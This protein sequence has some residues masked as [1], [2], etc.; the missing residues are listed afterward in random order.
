MRGRFAA[1]GAATAAVSM[2]ALATAAVAGASG[3]PPLPKGA[4][5]AK[6]QL[7]A[8]GL[9]TPTS[10]AFG[11][12]SVFAGDGGAESSKTPNGGIYVL[13]QGA[14]TKIAG[15][16]SFVAGLAWHQGALYVSGGGITKQGPQFSIWKMSGWNGTSFAKRQVIFSPGGKFDGFNGLAFGADGRLYVGVDL[17]LTN[18][19]DHGPASAT[20]HLYQILS[21]KP[22]GK[23]VTTFAKGIRQPWQFVFPAGSSS[24]FVSALGQ[25]K[26]AKTAPDFILRVRQ[27][28]DY[29]FPACNQTEPKACKGFTKPFQQFAPH[30]DL[31][32]MAIIGSRLY[33]TSFVSTHPSKN[34]GGEVVTMPLK[35][36]SL[37][38]VATGFV[39]P[40]VG[41]G[42]Q[43]GWLYV[44]EVG[45]GL[46]Y[47]IK[48]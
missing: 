27:G 3:P 7:F 11:G 18:G 34:S 6:V 26:G 23:D 15:S 42:E 19:N 1:L 22:N 28:D 48:P 44:G 24:P 21:L 41:L 8:S 9:K 25:D 17:G 10:F 4:N 2:G 32:G 45:P 14:A 39:A 16:P 29:G 5:G 12:G 30:T 37:K 46:V 31:M 38:P 40:T 13:K 33:M 20:P 36:G 35:G 47:R 43:S